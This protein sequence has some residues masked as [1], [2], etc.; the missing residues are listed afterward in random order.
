MGEW[1]DKAQQ[2]DTQMRRNFVLDLRKS[3]ATYRQIADA[4]I[5]RF[6]ADDLPN[7]Y[8][9]RYAYQDVARELDKL[10]AVVGDLAEDV[11]ELEI[12]RLDALLLALWPQAS[13]GNQGAVDRVL[14]IMERRSKLLGLDA[15]TRQ[16]FSGIDGGAIVI[17]WPEDV[18][19]GSSD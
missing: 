9:A 18:G 5:K 11:R 19:K 17:R 7:G 6:G 12:Q 1:M 4:A 2:I 15:P 10:K 13:K 8:D 16:E 3:G 14:R